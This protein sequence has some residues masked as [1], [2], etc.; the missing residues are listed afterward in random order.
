MNEFPFY[1][2]CLNCKE[3]PEVILSDNE[4]LFIF[5]NN[6]KISNTEK[7]KNVVNYS[8]KWISNEI[9]KFCTTKHKKKILSN[10]FCKTCKLFLCNECLVNIK[11]TM[12][13]MNL[14]N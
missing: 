9:I 2:S 14:L 7:I 13:I 8:S 6:C 1:F 4:N 12:K 11:L 3:I 10:I 5:F